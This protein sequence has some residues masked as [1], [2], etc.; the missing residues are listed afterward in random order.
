[1]LDV[2]C[3]GCEPVGTIIAGRFDLTGLDFSLAQLRLAR[4]LLTA[5]GFDVLC[6]RHV[7]DDV[8]ERDG[9]H[10]FVLGRA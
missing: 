6:E 1:M 8:S 2:G 4:E 7:R 10:V 5:T 3:G 9:E